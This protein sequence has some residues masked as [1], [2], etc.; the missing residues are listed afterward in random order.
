MD[1]SMRFLLRVPL[2]SDSRTMT[3]TI[4]NAIESMPVPKTANVTVKTLAGVLLDMSMIS[5]KPM[6]EIVTNVM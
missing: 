2:M 3:V 6:V 5:P 4:E 1:F